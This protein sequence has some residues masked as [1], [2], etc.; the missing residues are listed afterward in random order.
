MIDP[1]PPPTKKIQKRW[2]PFDRDDPNLEIN[3][4]RA[5]Y[6]MPPIDRWN[7]GVEYTYKSIPKCLAL[8]TVLE[9]DLW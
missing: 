7:I 8:L 9:E 1:S 5:Q 2:N 4:D 6:G 3:I